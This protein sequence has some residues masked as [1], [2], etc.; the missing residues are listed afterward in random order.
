VSMNTL[1]SCLRGIR[2]NGSAIRFP[3]PP[4]GI[5]SWLGKKRS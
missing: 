5:V 1:L 4:L 3:N 2:C